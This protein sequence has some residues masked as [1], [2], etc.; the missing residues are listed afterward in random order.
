M[1]DRD[2]VVLIFLGAMVVVALVFF[3][4]AWLEGRRL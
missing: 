2:I 4:L 3:F 1:E